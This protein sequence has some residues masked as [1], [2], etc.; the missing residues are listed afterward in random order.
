MVASHDAK[1]AAVS[2][3]EASLKVEA[4]QLQTELAETQ[5]ARD[6]A[7]AERSALQSQVWFLH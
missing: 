7:L 6:G 4:Q 5:A 3:A 1:L 2:R